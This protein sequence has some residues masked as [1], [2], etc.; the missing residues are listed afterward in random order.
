ML[1]YGS[2]PGVWTEND[3]SEREPLLDTYAGTYVKEE[4]QAE[5]LT[6][7]LEGF[8]RFIVAIAARATRPLDYTK[9]ASQAAITRASA[10][11]FVE[12]LEDTL[13]VFRVEPF[14]RRHARRIVQHP[15]YY[16]FDNGVL[17]G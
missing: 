3:R 13:L 15:R 5:A 2:L 12:I 10:I 4:I 9:V 11:R 8:A 14:A 6:R 1:A 16:F 17:N 7:N